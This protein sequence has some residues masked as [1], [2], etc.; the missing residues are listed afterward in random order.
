MLSPEQYW[1]NAFVS[2]VALV[3]LLATKERNEAGRIHEK[4]M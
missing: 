4:I 3:T 2:F 1:C